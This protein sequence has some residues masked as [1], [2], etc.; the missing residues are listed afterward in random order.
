MTPERLSPEQTAFGRKV[1]EAALEEFMNPEGLSEH[2]ITSVLCDITG[3]SIAAH[4]KE[5]PIPAPKNTEALF[6]QFIEAC[7]VKIKAATLD[8]HAKRGDYQAIAA[9]DEKERSGGLDH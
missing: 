5:V 4:A 2:E 8:Y 9:M 7:L 1:I 6:H 3:Y